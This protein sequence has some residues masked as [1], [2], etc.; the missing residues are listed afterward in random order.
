MGNRKTPLLLRQ[1]NRPRR[2]RCRILKRRRRG[3]HTS[4]HSHRRR[5][6]GKDEL[7]VPTETVA[8]HEVAKLQPQDTSIPEASLGAS[9]ISLSCACIAQLTL[10]HPL[11]KAPYLSPAAAYA[12]LTARVH[13]EKWDAP[14]KPLMKWLRASLYAARPG[15]TPLPLLELADHITVSRQNLLKSMVPSTPSS[16]AA[17]AP[18]YII[19]SQ[20]ASQAT[21]AKKKEP[22]ERWD[23]QATLST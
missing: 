3:K 10:A 6:V 8:D 7:P 19:Q 16:P 13:A 11:L 4:N 21:P 22:A 23:L 17:P 20:P 15:V 5:M 14:L 1:Q 2:S 12:L 18:M 9:T